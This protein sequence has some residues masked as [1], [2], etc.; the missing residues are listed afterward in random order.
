MTASQYVTPNYEK[1]VVQTFYATLNDSMAGHLYV[2]DV[3]ASICIGSIVGF[4]ACGGDIQEHAPTIAFL[5]YFA[6]G[7][8]GAKKYFTAATARSARRPGRPRSGSRWTSG[9][10]RRVIRSRSRARSMRSGLVEHARAIVVPGLR[11]LGLGVHHEGAALDD[12]LVDR[13]IPP[14]R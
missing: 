7:D 10:E 11:D 12:G 6:C 2:V 14:P 3:G 5:R 9:T 1:S 13:L 4:G 8:Q